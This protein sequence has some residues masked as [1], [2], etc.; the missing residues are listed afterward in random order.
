MKVK[1]KSTATCFRKWIQHNLSTLSSPSPL[2]RCLWVN[3]YAIQRMCKKLSCLFA[4]KLTSLLTHFLA[5]FYL[6]SLSCL[7]EATFTLADDQT[8]LLS[9][10][11]WFEEKHRQQDESRWG[12]KRSEVAKKSKF[13]CQNCFYLK[14]LWMNEW[15]NEW[16]DE[17]QLIFWKK[18]PNFETRNW[19]NRFNY[20]QSL[21]WFT[22]EI[23]FVLMRMFVLFVFVGL[24]VDL[25][26]V[27][28]VW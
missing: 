3:M 8:S 24:C 6:F 25:E 22:L 11:G 17:N 28:E 4:T 13:L 23:V 14:D 12:R 5:C 2:T 10:G 19:A 7:L 26:R 18:F 15:I 1:T 20:L 27:L 9:M 16:I 21:L